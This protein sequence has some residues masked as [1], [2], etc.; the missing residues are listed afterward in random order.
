MKITNKKTKARHKKD[1]ETFKEFCNR[2]RHIATILLKIENRTETVEDYVFVLENNAIVQISSIIGYKSMEYNNIIFPVKYVHMT[3]SDIKTHYMENVKV[4]MTDSD[5]RT[6]HMEDAKVNIDNS[7][8]TNSKEMRRFYVIRNK[9]ETGISRT[10]RILEGVVTQTGKV[11]VEWRP[12][13]STVA[14]YTSMQEFRTIHIDSHPSC[15]E[16]IW[17]D[18]DKE[19]AEL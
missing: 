19:N 9:D 16:I 11:I 15:N 13:Y 3:D 14:I 18:S 7:F 1:I 10:G 6:H 2:L 5:N 4:N 8:S 12:P 17:L